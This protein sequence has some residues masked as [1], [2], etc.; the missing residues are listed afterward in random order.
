MNPWVYITSRTVLSEGELVCSFGCQM[1]NYVDRL[2]PMHPLC[3]M[4]DVCSYMIDIVWVW[5]VGNEG[6]G[7]MRGEP[8]LSA[9]I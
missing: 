1:M 8:M 2:V 9:D 5:G 6:G 7:H 4:Y 3:F